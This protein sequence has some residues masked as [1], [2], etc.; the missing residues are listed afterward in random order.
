MGTVTATVRNVAESKFISF[1]PY[2]LLIFIRISV[3]DAFHREHRV[4]LKEVAYNGTGKVHA[5][6]RGT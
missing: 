4:Q 2:L 1:L 6:V 3:E 5:I